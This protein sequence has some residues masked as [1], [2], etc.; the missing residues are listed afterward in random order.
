MS[1]SVIYTNP[2]KKIMGMY[3]PYIGVEFGNNLPLIDCLLDSGADFSTLPASIGR[4][5]GIDFSDEDP[6]SDPPKQI[7][8]KIKCK[9]YQVSKGIVVPDLKNEQIFIRPIWIDSNEASAVLG[10]VDFFKQFKEVS[11]YEG[12]KKVI[13]KK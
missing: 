12:K 11:F 8:G 2:Y 7:S 9:C 3:R 1:G 4:K 6:L 13:F 5:A 10:R